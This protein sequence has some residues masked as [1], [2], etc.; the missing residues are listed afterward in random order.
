MTCLKSRN[1]AR[2][3][4]PCP[5][6]SSTDFNELVVVGA[7]MLH[8]QS[9]K[10]FLLLKLPV[11]NF[12]SLLEISRKYNDKYAEHPDLTDLDAVANR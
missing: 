1:I 6:M 11:E 10:R 3:S 8:T 2:Q 9:M 4:T 7:V 12:A 5:V